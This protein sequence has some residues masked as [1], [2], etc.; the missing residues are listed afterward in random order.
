[1]LLLNFSFLCFVLVMLIDQR[2]LVKVKA[3]MPNAVGANLSSMLRGIMQIVIQ[4]INVG[5]IVN[6]ARSDVEHPDCVADT[7]DVVLFYTVRIIGL[8]ALF[9]LI[10]L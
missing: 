4:N 7:A 10:T 9:P 3:G 1:M 8:A 6:P 2:W 5:S